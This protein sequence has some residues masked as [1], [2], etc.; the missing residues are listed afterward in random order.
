MGKG[1][2][3]NFGSLE[4]YIYYRR[5]NAI[6]RF[7]TSA[8]FPYQENTSTSTQYIYNLCI[9]AIPVKKEQTF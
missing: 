9:Y 4:K 1:N 2:K 6:Q 7:I 8:L 3:T 5:F